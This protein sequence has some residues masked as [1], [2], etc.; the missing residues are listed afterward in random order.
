MKRFINL[1]NLYQMAAVLGCM[2][3]GASAMSSCSD[4]MLTGQPSWLGN[5][6][7]ERLQDEGNYQTTLRLIDDLGQKEVLSKTGSKTLFVADDE[8]Y[9]EW[10]RSNSWGVRSY[11]QLSEAQKKMLFNNSMI[12][13][14]YLIE[15][16]S[17]LSGNPPQEG[18]CMRRATAAS[19]FDSVSVLLP[20]QMPTTPFWDKHRKKKDGILILKDATASPMIHFMP[21]FMH[22]NQITD[23]DLSSLTNGESS[24]IGDA[25]VNGKKVIE[26]DITCKNG[27]IQKVSGVIESSANIAEILRQHPNMSLWSHLIDRYSAPYYSESASRSWHEKTGRLD[28]VYVLRYF[29]GISSQR[30]PLQVDPDDEAVEATLAYDPGWNQYFNYGATTNQGISNDAAVMIVPKD[31]ALRYWWEHDGKVLQDEYHEWDSIPP[32]VL[33][34]LLN[35]NMLNSFTSSVPSKFGSILNDAKMEM[36]IKP[37]HI[38]SCFMGCNGVVYLSNRVFAPSAYS[39][40]SFPA[41]IHQD[42]MSIIYWAITQYDFSPFLNSME[43]YYSFFIPTNNAM[44]YYIDPTTYGQP[45][46]ILYEFYWDSKALLANRVK[47]RRYQIIFDPETG[48][49]TIGSSLGAATTAQIRN[50]LTD[51]LDMLIVVGDVESGQDYYKTKGG[52]VV[53]V[54]N[55]GSPGLMT[56]SGGYQMETGK[57][58]TV[59]TIY[60]QSTS[61]NGKSYVT[62]QG[63]ILGASKSVYTTL[64]ENKDMSLF[65]EM[66]SG[67]DE[68]STKYNILITQDGNYKCV[69]PTNNY[70]IRL[71]DKFNYTVYVP[72]NQ[73]IQKL[74]DDGFLPTWDDYEAQTLEAWNDDDAKLRAAH[75]A[76]RNR[77]FNFVRYHI[78]DNAV[79]I[80]CDPVYNTK[81]ETSKL[82]PENQRFFSLEVNAGPSSLSVTDQLGNTRHVLT[83]Q[84]LYNKVCREY[85]FSGTGNNMS[86][87]SASDAVVHQIDGVLLYNNDLMSKTWQ[88]ELNEIRNQSKKP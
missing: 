47:A 31:E 10:F 11:E 17:N 12:N 77:I 15:L 8:A 16:L 37:E 70:N 40:V 49:Y 18:M 38:D 73:S 87:N 56:V 24:S 39:S 2:L 34:E 59:S 61:G 76:I 71:F 36:G 57:P 48:D 22:T 79:Y 6:I 46:Q 35:V 80:G 81:F 51:L 33:A 74:I 78:Q 88:Q 82:N 66:L 68:D 53:K 32:L 14:A 85:W 20:S 67:N 21:A 62:D 30:A 45:V 9:A 7:Y 3:L 55:A 4:D 27:Y 72:T 63:M 58:L 28:S 60:D 64:K 42:I 44:L 26:R 43:S 41:L 5:S 23:K 1:N 29:S 52:S 25:W 69:D 19:E 50:R 86:I 84:G 13:N 75:A 54:T 65:L 83:Q